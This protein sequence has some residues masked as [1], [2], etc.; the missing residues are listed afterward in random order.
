MKIEGVPFRVPDWEQI[1]P[2]EHAGETGTATWRTIETGNIRVRKVDYSPGYRADHWCER[3]HVLLVLDGELVTELKDGRTFVMTAGMN[4]Q[5][6]DGAEPHR[7]STTTGASL[8]IV[9]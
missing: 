9:D 7:S 3:G 1:E 8:F 6:A 4:Y 5:V 2:V